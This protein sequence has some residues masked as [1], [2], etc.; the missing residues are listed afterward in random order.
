MREGIYF[1]W[2]GN[3]EKGL[4]GYMVVL[5]CFFFLNFF[6]GQGFE[7]RA[8]FL[9]DGALPLEPYLQPEMIIFYS[10]YFFVVLGFKLRA[11]TLSHST[12]HPPFFCDGF[13]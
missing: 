9:L 13:S 10:F 8:L 4:L 12:S 1:L 11:Y 2:V 3:P 7:L 6:S 5:F